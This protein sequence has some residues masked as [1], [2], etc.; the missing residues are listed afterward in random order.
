MEKAKLKQ[1]LQRAEEADKLLDNITD[2][3]AHL[4]NET[5]ETTLAQPFETVS[6]FIWEVI[7]YLER[8]IEETHDNT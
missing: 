1:L 8:E 5:L 7:K 3:L 6:R 2:H 4:Q